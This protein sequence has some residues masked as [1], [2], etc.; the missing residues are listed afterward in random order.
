MQIKTYHSLLWVPQYVKIVTVVWMVLCHSQYC[1]KL[2][3]WPSQNKIY[4]KTIWCCM[5][6][7][8]YC[9]VVSLHFLWRKVLNFFPKPWSNK[10]NLKMINYGGQQSWK[11]G[12]C[13]K[14][15]NPNCWHVFPRTKLSLVTLLSCSPGL[16]STLFSHASITVSLM[17]HHQI[18]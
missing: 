2:F 13:P 3:G 7:D 15:L 17:I 6:K 10:N 1:H 4:F 5:S 11:N 8:I 16:N 9:S 12:D 18:L 14:S